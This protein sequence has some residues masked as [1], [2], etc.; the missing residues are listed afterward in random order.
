[1]RKAPTIEKPKPTEV[2]PLK[3]DREVALELIAEALLTL[4]IKP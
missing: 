1:M 2:K 4:I 3:S